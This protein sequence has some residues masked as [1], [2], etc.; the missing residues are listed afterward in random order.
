[1]P[2]TVEN[3]VLRRIY[4]KKRGWVFTPGHFRDLGTDVGIRKALQGLVDRG[5]IRHLARGLYQYPENHPKLGLL[6][7]T[8]EQI[9]RALAGKDALRLQPS[10]AY[11]ANL[12]GL[13]EQVPAKAV[14]L[15]DGTNRKIKVGRQE[16]ILQQTTPKNMAT[17]GR[18]SGLVI[19]ALRY[20]GQKHMDESHVDR[21]RK[22]LSS[23][24][25][26]KL[27][28]DIRYAPAWI[29]DIFRR[30]AAEEK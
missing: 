20:L 1:M 27:I 17:A 25:R 4:G 6:N 21:L 18:T 5:L 14:F 2:Q 13:S 11:A 26:E 29:G 28:T 7:P 30:L 8:A 22:R 10:G 9:A 23:T 15:T 3:K 12:L 16:I 19:Q 24:D